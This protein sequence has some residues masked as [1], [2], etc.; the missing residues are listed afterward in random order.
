MYRIWIGVFGF[1]LGSFLLCMCHGYLRKRSTLRSHCDA[2]HH[3]LH[4]YD[5]IPILSYICL[6]GRC[7]YCGRRFSKEYI[8]AEILTGF[9]CMLVVWNV[10]TF[11]WDIMMRVL[12]FSLLWGVW[13][14]DYLI[15]EIPNEIHIGM[16]ILFIIH[17]C[18]INEINI[19]PWIRM[20]VMFVC[21]YFIFILCEKLFHKECIGGGDLKLLSCMSLFLSFQKIWIVLSIACILAI[22]W[23]VFHQKNCIAFGPFLSVSFLLVFCGYFDS[24]SWGL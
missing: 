4:W 9:L 23:M 3:I 24:L 11:K 5:L 19:Q 1:H 12:L 16:I 22:S 18:M 17:A 20:L 21:G 8:L 2:C 14:I 6:R 7:R 10:D 15:M 13:Y